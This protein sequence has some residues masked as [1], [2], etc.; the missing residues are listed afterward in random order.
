VVDAVT[1]FVATVNIA[2]EAP[3]GMMTVAGTVALPLLDESEIVA[4]TDG[5]APFRVTVPVAEPPPPTDVGFIVNPV[6]V[7][8]VIVSVVVVV[9]PLRLAVRIGEIELD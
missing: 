7:A 6:S 4:P 9:V 5:A 8:G 3:L 2:L 1:G